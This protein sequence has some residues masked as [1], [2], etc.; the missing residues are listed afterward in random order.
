M[1]MNVHV[2]VIF[3]NVLGVT[4]CDQS[5]T[6]C[7]PLSLNW[8]SSRHCSC[9]W[10][11]TLK[12]KISYWSG[13]Y[14]PVTSAYGRASTAAEMCSSIGTKSSSS[15]L[16][17]VTT[18]IQW[19]PPD[20][21]KHVITNRPIRREYFRISAQQAGVRTNAEHMLVTPACNR[22]YADAASFEISCIQLSKNSQHSKHFKYTF[23]KLQ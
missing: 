17:A 4:K 8:G 10:L 16:S 13:I 6:I 21:Q 2:I 7:F 9:H 15:F 22:P 18:Q 23:K 1:C 3:Q 19:E 20:T 5:F 14:T 11:E 12:I